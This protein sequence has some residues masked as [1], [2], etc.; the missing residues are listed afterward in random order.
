L[1]AGRK[2]RQMVH[3]LTES[4][5]RGIVTLSEPQLAS[6]ASLL[7]GSERGSQLDA[8]S[9]ETLS[10]ALEKA[11]PSE[12]GV[13]EAKSLLV[14]RA[15]VSNH[16]KRLR[17]GE[18]FRR[19]KQAEADGVL[20]RLRDGKEVKL[21][22]LPSGFAYDM[23]LSHRTRIAAALRLS[24]WLGLGWRDMCVILVPAAARRLASVS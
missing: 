24:G 12:A 14:I 10:A 6:S 3:S 9:K 21:P 20:R 1:D 2:C 4:H 5:L 17:R 7:H 16:V 11:A 22:D 18:H 23:F 15:S 8:A 13:A 19:N